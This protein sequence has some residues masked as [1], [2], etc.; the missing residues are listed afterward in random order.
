MWP[1][2]HLDKNKTKQ[3]IFGIMSTCGL[4]EWCAGTGCPER[5]WMPCPWWR[6]RPDWMGPWAAW[7]GIK[8]G[9]WWPC[10]WWGGGA[11]WSLI[12]CIFKHFCRAGY[13][14][15][16]LWGHRI[17]VS[18]VVRRDNISTCVPGSSL[19]CLSTTYSLLIKR[20]VSIFSVL[21]Q[22]GIPYAHNQFEQSVRQAEMLDWKN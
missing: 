8:C 6:S 9:S 11:S 19:P 14:L 7:S 1:A 18:S 10:L 16:P 21:L 13:F 12:L 3:F 17:L 5:L 22:M 20:G 2:V 15:P 4:R